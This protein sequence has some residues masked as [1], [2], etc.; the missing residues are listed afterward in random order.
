MTCCH[1]A[2]ALLPEGEVIR[3]FLMNIGY[4]TAP[5]MCW[6]L[7]EGFYHTGNRRKYGER[8]LLFSIISELPF[9]LAL[10]E[11]SMNM[12]FSLFLCFLVLE[13]LEQMPQGRNRTGM[14]VLLAAVSI[15]S[16]WPILAVAFTFL[17]DRYRGDKTTLR[18]VYS[19]MAVVFMLMNFINYC[20]DFPAMTAVLLAIQCGCSI[21]LSGYAVLYLYNGKKADAGP[22]MRRFNKWFFYLYY[23]AHLLVIAGIRNLI[24]G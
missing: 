18:M 22:F 20:A 17:F 5:T 15:C 10:R 14:L 2:D 9:Y 6:F 21:L 8:L 1:A 11:I 3:A 4:F 7:V 13:V 12:I 16:D 24:N 19:Y 23:P